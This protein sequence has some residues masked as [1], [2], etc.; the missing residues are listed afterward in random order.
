MANGGVGAPEWLAMVDS[1]GVVCAVVHSLPNGTDVTTQMGL[2]HRPFAAQVAATANS[3]SRAG[4]GVSTANLYLHAANS[5]GFDAEINSGAAGAYNFG[6][7]PYDGNPDTWGTPKDPYVGKRVGG[8]NFQAGGL[9][10]YNNKHVKVGAIGVSGDFR[11]TDHVVAW[12][13]REMLRDG[14]Y[15]ATNNPFGLSSNHTDAMIQDID[16]KTGKSASGFG[17]PVCLIN[18]P[19]NDND[20]DAIEGN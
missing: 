10:L 4:I 8:A 11:C 3:Y 2:I 18:N 12:K 9:P 6:I 14:A 20:A 13:V 7:N 19:T 5:P 15:T 1:S 16:P 17:Y